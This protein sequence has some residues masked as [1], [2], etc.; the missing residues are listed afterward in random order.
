M[1]NFAETLLSQFPDAVLSVEVDAARSEL[2]ARV[3]ASRILD[4]ARYLH[5]AP[6]A[7]FDHITDICSVDYPED[8]ERFEV[9]YHLH[10]LPHRRRIRLKARVTENEPTIASVTGIWHGAEFME[11]EVYDMM[12]IT[13]S[14][15]PDLRRILLPENYAEG[16]P[17]RKDFPTEGRGWRSQFDFIPR[18]DEAPIEMTQ[19]EIPEEQR[20]PFLAGNGRSGTRRREELLLNM[21]PQHPS[22]HG[23]LRVVLELDG[24]RIVKAT[25]DLGYLHRGVEK[26]SEGLGYMQII[27]H[28]DRLDYVCAMANNYAYV[29]AVE[30]LLCIS[31][32]ERAEYI[33]TIVAEMQRIIGHLF[34]LGTQSLDIGAMTVFFWTFR[35]REVLLDL[36][37]KLCGARLTLNYYRIGGVDSDFTPDLIAR[38]K[39]F[40]DTFQE[41]VAEYDAL[42][43]SNRIWV[44]RTKNV[45]VI[46]AVDAINFGCT[47]PVLRGS[48]VAYDVRKFEPYG[49]YDKV[50]WEVPVGKNGDTYDRYWVRMEEMRQSCRIIRQC[51]DQLPHGPIMAEDPQYIPPP[52]PKVMR[53]MESLI[54]HFILFTQGLKPPKGET[55]CGTE[56]PKGELGFF[57]VSDGSA[58]PYRLKIRAPSFIHMGA[59]DH[60]ARGYLISDIITIFG[61]Y[62]IV[63]GECDR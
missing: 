60:M 5:D 16:Y 53:D 59:F 40:L 18:L 17:L 2:S 52:K 62:D 24:E 46:S 50:D 58:R 7:L 38:L 51:L 41:K 37:E 25:P 56:A 33:R 22:T 28:T 34:W 57:I 44:G 19:G 55:Y 30:K 14:G 23:V 8:Q 63:M 48:G 20:K 4:V 36:F 6:E 32:P 61:T 45:A 49:A 29:R 54:H 21:G 13:F 3:S 12:G 39:A 43:M 27:P 10:S 47:G 31:V 35:E 26:L 1:Q 15:H 9:V 42:L 11:R